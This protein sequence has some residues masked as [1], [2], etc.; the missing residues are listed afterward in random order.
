MSKDK[1]FAGEVSGEVD[2]KLQMEAMMG[3]M[4]RILKLELEQVHERMDRI[5]NSRKERPQSSN[6]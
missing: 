2:P 1:N 6:W 4:R 3:E 5:E